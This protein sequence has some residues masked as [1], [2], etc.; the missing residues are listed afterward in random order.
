MHVAFLSTDK[1]PWA[2]GMRSVSAV[3]KADGHRT[4]LLF[5]QSD[6]RG[7]AKRTMD[8]ALDLIRDADVIGFSCLARGSERTKQVLEALRPLKKLT[9]WGGLHA[10]LYATE[11]VQWADIVCRGEGEGMMLE[12]LECLEQGKD[13]KHIQNAAYADNGQV[14]MNSLRPLVANLDELPLPDFSFE[15]EFHLTDKGF[16]AVSNLRGFAEGG[17]ILFTTSRGC[18]FHC[19]YCCNRKLQELYSGIGRYGR[20]MSVTKLIEHSQALRKAFPR[21]KYFFFVDDDFAAR[22][23]DELTQL[24]EE[25]PQKVG[26]PFE[27]FTH[28]LWVTQPKMDLLVKAGLWR[29]R[30]GIET[31]SERTRREIYDRHVTNQAMTRAAEI[32]RTYPQVVPY[33]FVIITNPYEERADVTATV[34]FMESL[35]LG[36]YLLTF[37]LVFFPGSALHERAVRDGLIGGKLDSGYE[38]D[39]LGGLHYEGHRW[40]RKNLYL[41]G[42]LFLMEGK[43]TPRRMG[44]LPRFTLSALLSPRMMDFNERHSVVIQTLIALKLFLLA[45]RRRGARLLKMILSD[46]TAVYNLRYHFRRVFARRE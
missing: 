12:L 43:S 2:L 46:P 38:L 16:V 10:S 13:W 34:R 24:S 44:S 4:R 9:V 3:L 22:S 15:N 7:Y 35:P 30:M 19:T 20:R 41:N 17:E 28:A 32:I 33:Y 23:V 1:D 8:E 5:M 18:P 36:Y 14:I 29:I 31:G 26:L 6:R 45:C 39:F 42:L 27:C 11:C 40:K 21:A 37:N 25:F